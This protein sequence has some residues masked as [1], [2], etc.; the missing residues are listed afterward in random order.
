MKACSLLS[1]S[2]RCYALLD[3]S[4]V[5]GK[6]GMR[7]GIRL[8]SAANGAHVSFLPLWSLK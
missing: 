3:A 5:S 7:N 4:V 2:Y 8:C 6:R 1:V